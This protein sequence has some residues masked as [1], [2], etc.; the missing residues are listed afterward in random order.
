MFRKILL[1]I[2]KFALHFLRLIEQSFTRF[3]ADLASVASPHPTAENNGCPPSGF[4]S[5][6][7][8]GLSKI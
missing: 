7:E 6:P 3:F 5:Y 8:R 1:F 4:L 2:K